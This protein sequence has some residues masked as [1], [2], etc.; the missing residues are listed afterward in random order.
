MM[1]RIEKAWTTFMSWPVIARRAAIAVVCYLVW[2]SCAWLYTLGL[3]DAAVFIGTVS[4]I[5]MF[6]AIGGL[7]VLRC[8]FSLI[9]GCRRN[10][11][12]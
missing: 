11:L 4:S 1:D 8:I 6:I 12:R 9:L 7:Y 3:H 5:G 2:L 10:F